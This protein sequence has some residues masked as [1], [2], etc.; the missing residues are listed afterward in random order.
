MIHSIST[1][2][3]IVLASLLLALAMIVKYVFTYNF[4]IG[5]V[6]FLRI[7]F[8]GVFLRFIAIILGPLYGG[9]A[10]G[11][12]DFIGYFS[13]AALG[14]YIW[15]LT[16]TE[17]LKY[18]SI[19]YLWIK[20]KNINFKLY[21][22]CYIT[23]FSIIGIWGLVNLYLLKIAPEFSYSA[24]LATIGSKTSLA[25]VGPIVICVI[26]LLTYFVPL[27]IMTTHKKTDMAFFEKYL[28][29]V[30]VTGVPSLICTTV[31]TFILKYF[32]A[33]AAEKA[34]AI[35][36]IPRV[37]EETFM[38]LLNVYL[39]IIFINIYEQHIRHVFEKN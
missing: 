14:P 1:T 9:I 38:V 33:A 30:F 23:V 8:H 5:G 31:N 7:S 22:V 35:F 10:G 15:G 6:P 4:Y 13:N 25:S 37:V 17:I 27:G 24:F 19:G 39:L 16:L 28:K 26:G 36:L 32:Y 29:L 34:F 3:K 2:R 11:L 12:S 21:S 18:A 20:I